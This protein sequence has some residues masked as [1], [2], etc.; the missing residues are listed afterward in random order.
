MNRPI[1]INEIE[2]VIKKKN[3]HKVQDDTGEF[4]KTFYEEL[5]IFLLKLFQKTE[6]EETLLNSFYEALLWY[7]NETR[8]PQGKKITDQCPPKNIDVK[9]ATK[10]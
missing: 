5:T 8:K 7:Q 1:T 10:Y 3:C 2:S 6:E 4:Y 9:T